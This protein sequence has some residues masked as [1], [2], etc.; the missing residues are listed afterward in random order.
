[1]E[2]E[3]IIPNM[4]ESIGHRPLRSRCPKRKGMS[5][6]GMRKRKRREGM[7]ESKG[8]KME[9]GVRDRWSR[10]PLSLVMRGVGWIWISYGVNK[11]VKTS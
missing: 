7:E 8:K 3:E 4:C 1:M 5:G 2:K 6:R 10:E 11:G 9:G